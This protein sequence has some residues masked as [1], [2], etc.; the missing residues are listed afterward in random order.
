MY[1]IFLF[2]VFFSFGQVFAQSEA[3]KDSLD[4]QLVKVVKPYTPKISDAFKI[5]QSPSLENLENSTKKAVDYTIFS[6][7]VASVFTPA[8]SKSVALEQLKREKKFS[9]VASFSGGNYT[10]VQGDLFLNTAISKGKNFGAYLSHYSSQGG[11]TDLIGEDNF[12]TNIA[13]VKYE[14]SSRDINW[15]IS[16]GAQ[17]Y[18]SN[19]Y[20]L[21]PDFNTDLQHSFDAKQTVS[22]FETKG[23]LNINDNV[24]EMTDVNF[25]FLLDDFDSKEIR[26][27]LDSKFNFELMNASIKTGIG[28]D[29]LKGSFAQS[30]SQNS[31]INYGNLTASISPTYNLNLSDFNMD[32]GLKVVY[33]N[34]LEHSKQKIYVY[35]K[36][37]TRISLVDSILIAYGGVDGNLFQN[38]YKDL[39]LENS[40]VSPSLVI[41]PTSMPYKLFLGTKGKLTNSLSYDINAAFSQQKDAIFFQKNGHNTIFN[42]MV[43]ANGNSFGLIY[44][45]L[46]TISFQGILNFELNDK[47]NFSGSALFNSYNLDTQ[48]KAWNLPEIK[49]TLSMRYYPTDRLLFG[50]HGFFV[51]ERF[52]FQRTESSSIP[53]DDLNKITSFDAFFDLNIDA[54]YVI[55]NRWSAT[56]KLNNILGQ[57]YQRWM[58]FPVQGFQISAGAFY[59]FDL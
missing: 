19:W 11:I 53:T 46:Q 47:F 14:V 10:T 57:N 58:H 39:Y 31:A 15:N 30:L 21:F 8:K 3:E 55:N 54:S 45:D 27:Q 38:T 56:L 42:S 28:L 32:I 33:F 37:T 12:S 5:K 52:D 36:I 26:G 16:A 1:I 17:R 35:P 2:G 4:T 40:F 18:V 7:P 29:V 22:V 9:N 13:K 20:G 49:S 6:V 43:F 48:D 51:G 34:D 59:K 23:G 44:D 24:F 25:Y 50:V 41:Q